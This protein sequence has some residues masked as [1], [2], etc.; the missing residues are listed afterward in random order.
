MIRQTLLFAALPAAFAASADCITDPP[1]IGDLGPSSELVCAEL[2]RRFPGAVSAVEDR[3][4]VA[5]DAVA[6]QVSVNGH[7]VI[8][9]YGLTGFDWTLMTPEDGF[10]AVR[11]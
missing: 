8:L 5:A 7:T 10:A 4:I 2:E 1:E 9:D 6:V 11:R 3:T